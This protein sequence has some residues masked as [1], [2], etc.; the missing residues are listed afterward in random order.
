[1]SDAIAVLV[2]SAYTL[3]CGICRAIS[4]L[5]GLL[6]GRS[7]RPMKQ[8]SARDFYGDFHCWRSVKAAQI[9]YVAWWLRG[10]KQQTMIAQVQLINE[11]IVSAERFL[12]RNQGT[13][14]DEAQRALT[15]A[16]AE[17]R[18]KRNELAALVDARQQ[19]MDDIERTR[20]LQ[21]FVQPYRVF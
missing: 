11:R 17:S 20:R 2:V 18:L 5:A 16:I 19:R 1:M 7:T 14:C 8:F 3:I 4:V 21:I 15:A 9:N 12:S 13:M 10:N 6:C